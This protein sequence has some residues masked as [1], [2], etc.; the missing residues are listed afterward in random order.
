MVSFGSPFSDT[1]GCKSVPE[2]FA[3]QCPRRKSDGDSAAPST[4]PGSPNYKYDESPTLEGEGEAVFAI[5]TK[6]RPLP[7]AQQKS[8]QGKRQST[9]PP[10]K[11]KPPAASVRPPPPPSRRKSTS[12]PHHSQEKQPSKTTQ[13]P[14]APPSRRLSKDGDSHPQPAARPHQGVKPA[15]PNRQPSNDSLPSGTSS[16][17]LNTCTE[18]QLQNPHEKPN[19]NLPEGFLCV[20]SK[21]QKRWYFFDKSTNKSVWAVEHIKVQK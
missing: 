15:P 7:P 14:P 20:W 5:T 1:R 19:V 16:A 4:P 2:A 21:S 6:K 17:N 3:S 9:G 12:G 8:D 10:Q 11:P 18:A 13:K